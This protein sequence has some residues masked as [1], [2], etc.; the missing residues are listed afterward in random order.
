MTCAVFVSILS[1]LFLHL[2]EIFLCHMNVP[3]PWLLL[4]CLLLKFL[5]LHKLV[6]LIEFGGWPSNWWWPAIGHASLKEWRGEVS[7]VLFNAG[8]ATDW[9]L[10]W[11]VTIFY[12]RYRLLLS[13]LRILRFSRLVTLLRSFTVY[14]G[15]MIPTSLNI[16][17]FFVQF[18]L[19]HSLIELDGPK[20]HSL[21]HQF[22]FVAIQVATPLSLFHISHLLFFQLF[23]SFLKLQL[24]CTNDHIWATSLRRPLQS[25]LQSQELILPE[26]LLILLLG[27]VYLIILLLLPSSV[28]QF[29]FVPNEFLV[30]VNQTTIPQYYMFT[31][32]LPNSLA[33]LSKLKILFFVWELSWWLQ[34]HSVF[35]IIIY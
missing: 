10:R 6:S 13:K 15:H 26:C 5:F 19:S 27:D 20:Q 12:W 33:V 21:L 30:L 31:Q 16:Y 11:K 23:L 3:F 24:F 32:K 8:A 34:V 4:S 29:G 1:L 22:L 9:R 18:I 25:T 28:V 35:V 17:D 2:H 14:S 7:S